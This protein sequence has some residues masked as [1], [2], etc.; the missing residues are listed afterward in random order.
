M[1]DGTKYS[2]TITIRKPKKLAKKPKSKV[3]STK[4]K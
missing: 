2:E 4:E 3:K 1:K